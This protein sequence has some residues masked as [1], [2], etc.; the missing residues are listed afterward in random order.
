MSDNLNIE[1]ERETN[2]KILDRRAERATDDEVVK[3]LKLA[4]L[5]IRAGP[6]LRKLV[7]AVAR[8]RAA[9]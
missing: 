7:G 2:A 9:S 3:A 8:K 1:L 5:E 6:E 4:A